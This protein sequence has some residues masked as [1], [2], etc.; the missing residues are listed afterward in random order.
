MEINEDTLLKGLSELE[1]E[2]AKG[3]DPLQNQPHDGGFATEGTNIQTRAKKMQK[4]LAAQGIEVSIEKARKMAKM[5]SATDM[6]TDEGEGEE[7]GG[8]GE[9]EMTMSKVWQDHGPASK[10]K[11]SGRR[12]YGGGTAAKSTGAADK[13]AAASGDEGE[14]FKKALTDENPEV[15]QMLDVSEFLSSFVDT[16]AKSHA[17]TTSSVEELAKALV[18]ERSSRVGFNTK[19]A[20]A[21]VGIG[22]ELRET[23]ELLN[24]VME[25]PVTP[26]RRAV[27]H[28][29]DVVQPP[30]SPQQPPS[31]GNPEMT[32]L[33]QVP[34][35][36]VQEAL[37]KKCI[38]DKSID[39]MVVTKFEN[40]K[41]DFRVLPRGI[42]K[43]LEQELCP[44]H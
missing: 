42:V 35:L 37:V 1:E 39:P 15:E 41:G 20:K 40:A 14:E 28:K 13:L 3:G 17:A 43:A 16:I 11:K 22:N 44:Q 7:E 12:G 24:Q 36:K 5:M 19:V 31:D 21:L 8:E 32:P 4:A 34:Y 18:D 2:I 9:E 30:L 33:H 38:E 27:L 26:Q 10:A 6:G 23:R 29:A 25:Q